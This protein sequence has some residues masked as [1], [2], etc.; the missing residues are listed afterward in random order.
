MADGILAKLNGASSAEEFFALLGVDY[1]AKIVNVARLHILR[2]MGQ[3]LA[4]EDFTGAA[5]DVVVERCRA[6]L[7]RAYA[8]FVASTP[9]DQRVF[10]VLKDAVAPQ[11]KPTPTLVQLGTLK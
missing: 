5:D 7:E 9:I 8:D 3:Y 2:R 11:A 10:K 6:V 1:D 4:G